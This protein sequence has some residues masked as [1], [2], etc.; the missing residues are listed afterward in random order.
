MSVPLFRTIHEMDIN[1]NK[2]VCFRV[3]TGRTCVLDAEAGKSCFCLTWKFCTTHVL[4]A[5]PNT[6]NVKQILWQSFDLPYVLVPGM[7]LGFNNRTSQNWTL[8]SWTGLNTPDPGSFNL[9]LDYSTNT[10]QLVI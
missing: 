8:T 5:V 1:D 4:D 2:P 10:Q 7:K 9:E 3:K 6:L